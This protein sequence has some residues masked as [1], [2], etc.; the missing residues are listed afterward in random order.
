M[1][2]KSG[3]DMRGNFSRWSRLLPA[4]GR[5]RRQPADG[6]ERL[7]WHAAQILTARLDAIEQ[8]LE[9][10]EHRGPDQPAA[11]T[12]TAAVEAARY[13]EVMRRLDNLE[14]LSRGGRGTYVGKNRVL[15]KCTISEFSLG[16]LVEADD[17]LLS[18]R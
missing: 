5:K 9:R 2:G 11:P 7:A 1:P 12:S 15:V 4:V 6:F 10:I 16:Y 3:R 13:T 8:R 18:P 17:V 14:R